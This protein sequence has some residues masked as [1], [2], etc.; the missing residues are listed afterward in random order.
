MNTPGPGA[1]NYLAMI[2][3]TLSGAP[4]AGPVM[5]GQGPAPAPPLGAALPPP[6]PADPSL[7]PAGPPPPPM[8]DP[9][10]PNM[11]AMPPPAPVASVGAAP[12]APQ[13]PQP[14]PFLQR[15]ASGIA[16]VPAKSTELR[17]PDLLAAQGLS[18][19]AKEGAIQAVT[20][21]SQRTAAGDFAIA[22]EQ[23]RQAG[24]RQDAAD[25]STAERGQEMEQRQADFD[26]SVK[27]LSQQSVDP[28]RFWTNAS[29]G[30]KIAVLL[31]A[32]LAGIVQGRTGQVGGGN[33]GVDTAMKLAD[34]DIK[35]QEFAYNAARDTVNARQTAF[36]MAMQ[37]YQNVDAARAAAR[38]AAM[39][40]IQA[41]L[42]QQAALWKGTDAA[43]RAT[44]ASASLQD[45]KMQQIA[46]GIMFTP[47]HQVA[48]G[49]NFVDTRTGITYTNKEAQGVAA[50]ID[51]RQGAED[52]KDKEI[53]GQVLVKREDN[54]G[55]DKEASGKEAKDIAHELQQAKVPQALASAETARKALGGAPL[56]K[57]ERIFSLES[58][59]M[60]HKFIYGKNAA[61]REQS[62]LQ[63]KNDALHTLSGAAISPTE[64]TRLNRQFEG[65]GDTESRLHAIRDAEAA[66][67]E[68]QKSAMAGASPAGQ[69]EFLRNRDAAKADGASPLT[70]I[71][72]Y[73]PTP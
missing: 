53:A 55:K 36:G 72:T 44:M 15:V 54:A 3:Q 40:T 20:E 58:L 37:K 24:V 42:G 69:A 21:R 29:V 61:E 49:G 8:P 71:K 18:N 45:E 12:L 68:V 60:A 51:T 17:G 2:S 63:F 11:S 65:A 35:A 43:N 19:A 31:S 39:D 9:G 10:G 5:L 1:P 52:L 33:L 7:P 28:D 64:M 48:V 23:Q 32:G 62:W 14:A 30:R 59:P 27:A 34:A 56:S 4:P 6:A 16:N 67:Q 38:A 47:G 70:N 57:A 41:Q 26:Q 73:K 13:P 46:Q 25:Y 50:A 22:L 66:L